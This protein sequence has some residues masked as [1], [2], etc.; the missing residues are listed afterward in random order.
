MSRE[1]LIIFLALVFIVFTLATEVQ[2]QSRTQERANDL[3]A[4]LADNRS[5]Q[6]GLQERLR[7]LA[8]ELK[9]ENIEKSLAGIGSTHPEELRD[10]R[11]RQLELEK[12]S[13]ETQLKILAESRPTLEKG[14][15]QA[16]TAAY[17]L[18]AGVNT[19]SRQQ[20][21]VQQV[22]TASVERRARRTKQK[23]K[24]PPGRR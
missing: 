14:I 16:D 4:Q 23:P 22:G 6:E 12:I 15:V 18:S 11:R 7:E 24:R 3:R 17:H 5:K 10:F 19:G 9:P 2:G 8:E 13:V 20:N 1:R 21:A